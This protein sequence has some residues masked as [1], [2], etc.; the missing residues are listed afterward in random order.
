MDCD[1]SEDGRIAECADGGL[2][3]CGGTEPKD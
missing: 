3:V 2:G 1:R